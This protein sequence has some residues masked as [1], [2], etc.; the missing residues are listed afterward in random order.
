[1]EIFKK[2]I[3]KVWF[4]NKNKLFYFAILVGLIAAI[5]IARACIKPTEYELRAQKIKDI[6]D[7]ISNN[8]TDEKR[9]KA[10]NDSVYNA[11]I[12][13]YGIKPAR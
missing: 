5:L 1:M 13:Q 12:K 7:S 10:N 2:I 4:M 6:A 11:I 8:K 9:I 3:G